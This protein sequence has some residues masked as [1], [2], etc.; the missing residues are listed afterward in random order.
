MWHNRFSEKENED[1]EAHILR[2]RDSKTKKLRHGNS[3]TK[4]P[5]HPEAETTKPRH[6]DS[7]AFFR[8]RKV[9]TSKVPDWKTTKMNNEQHVF[10]YKIYNISFHKMLYKS[11]M[12]MN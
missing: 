9:T 8:E 11:Y 6:R 1:V 7:R 10:F 5:R 12:F 4:T 2:Y 3:A